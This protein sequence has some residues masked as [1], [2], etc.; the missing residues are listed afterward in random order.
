MEAKLLEL[1]AS[2]RS[3]LSIQ[4]SSML[5]L[6]PSKDTRGTVAAYTRSPDEVPVLTKHD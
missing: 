3:V 2:P 1:H 4:A 6:L 5:K